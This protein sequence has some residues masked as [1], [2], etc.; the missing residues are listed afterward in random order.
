[1]SQATES[2]SAKKNNTVV[3][4]VVVIVQ[5]SIRPPGL[6]SIGMPSIRYRVCV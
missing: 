4:V 1:M 6:F 3:V 5:N 2:S